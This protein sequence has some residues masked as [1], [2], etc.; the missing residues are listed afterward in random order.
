MGSMPMTHLTDKKHAPISNG[1]TTMK[2]LL[3][4]TFL[5]FTATICTSADAYFNLGVCCYQDNCESY[6]GQM[7]EQQCYTFFGS[8]YFPN[9][10]CDTVTCP[11]QDETFGA[12][13]YNDPNLG[14]MCIETDR[15]TCDKV[16]GYFYGGIPCECAPE[17]VDPNSCEVLP[18]PN[19]VGPPQY[20]DPDYLAFGGGDIAVQTAS[21]VIRAGSNQPN[22]TVLMIFDLTG[23]FTED[24]PASLLRY[25]HPSWTGNQGNDLGSILGLALDNDGNIYVTTT[26]TWDGTDP[27]GFGGWGAVYKIDTNTALPSLFATIPMTNNESGL[28]SITYDCAHQQFFVSSFED[29]LIYRLN[30]NGN[31][32]DSFDH[33][34]AYD[35]SI[36]GPVAFGDRPWA[37]E[38]HGNRLYYSLWNEN[39]DETNAMSNEIWSVPLNAAYAPVTGAEVLEITMQSPLGNDWTSPVSDIDFSDQGTMFTSERTQTS[40]SNIFA[41]GAFLKEYECTTSGWALTSNN[42]HVGTANVGNGGNSAGGVDATSSR[43]WVSADNMHEHISGDMIYGIQ[44][45]HPTGGDPTTSVLIDYQDYYGVNDK[46]M[47]GDLVV[48]D[49][50]GNGD[51]TGACCYLDTCDWVCQTTTWTDCNTVY[52]GTFY[53]NTPCENIDCPDLDFG[54][55]CFYEGGIM[56]CAEIPLLNCNGLNGTWHQ[57]VPCN[58]DPCQT[59]DPTGAC[60]FLDVDSGYMICV[61]MTQVECENKPESSYA[62]DYTICDDDYCCKPIGACCVNG[63]CLLVS[64]EQCE[65]ATGLYYGDGAVCDTIECEYCAGDLDKDGDVDVADLLILIAAWGICP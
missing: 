58:C 61:E 7:T 33:G 8:T 40:F 54:S 49:G 18:S 42:F 22:G 13:C 37:V 52:G 11:S 62:G 50:G 44:G 3:T 41:H 17:C 15:Y 51:Q 5:F 48:S 45:L 2:Q 19:C 1:M 16:L 38:V 55:C 23:P 56:Y 29:G 32:L 59:S 31:I 20:T 65:I 64:I 46:G 60:C 25:S 39:K 35:S 53:L 26:K 43:I 63:Q 10:T 28:G 12:C 9:D 21:P 27:V 47:L 4:I 14:M 36:G 30:M 6:C 57:G 24:V 34:P